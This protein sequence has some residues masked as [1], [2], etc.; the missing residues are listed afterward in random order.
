MDCIH[1]D[2]C[3]FVRRQPAN[4]GYLSKPSVAGS[5]VRRQKSDVRWQGFCLLFSVLC[6]LFFVSAVS[7]SRFL[8]V[9]PMG[10]DYSAVLAPSGGQ[11]RD[12]D[13]QRVRTLIE[14]KKLSEQEAEF[15]KKQSL[16][17]E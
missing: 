11:P 15:Y 13:M 3:R 12:I 7:V 9:V 2:R 4:S 16:N 8:Q 1:C 6:I 10:S 17:Q 5:D 14:Q